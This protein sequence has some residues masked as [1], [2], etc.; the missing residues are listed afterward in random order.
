MARCA[1][2]AVPY[3]PDLYSLG[4]GEIFG[5]VRSALA[6]RS[7]LS[8]PILAICDSP[9]VCCPSKIRLHADGGTNMEFEPSDWGSVTDSSSGDE[10][11]YGAAVNILDAVYDCLVPLDGPVLVSQLMDTVL[12]TF[13]FSEDEV[14]EAI[15]TWTALG[16]IRRVGEHSIVLDRRVEGVG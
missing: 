9:L 6:R 4:G 1:L 3:T 13:V 2:D 15:R 7:S 14:W 16:V 8:V 10:G 12:G 11:E 5:M